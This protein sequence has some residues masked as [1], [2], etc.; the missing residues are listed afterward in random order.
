MKKKCI[1]LALALLIQTVS[2][3]F[4]YV[5]ASGKDKPESS[6]C[7]WPSEMMSQ[8]FGFQNEMR[9]VLL[10]SKI[11]ERRFK[12]NIWKGWL[13]SEQV[14]E[15][16][17]TAL[18]LVTSSV[19]N[20]TRSIASNLITS[21]VLFELALVSVVQS[22]ADWIGIL[23]KDRPIVRDYKTML[24]IESDLF[25]VAYFRSKQVNL[26]L[27]VEWDMVKQLKDVIKKYQDSWLL[28]ENTVELKENVGI[29]HV[30]RDLLKMNA[31]MK[32]FMVYNTENLS[33]YRWCM[34]KSSEKN[35]PAVLQ[36]SDEAVEKLKSDY[37]WTFQKCNSHFNVTISKTMSDSWK[38]WWQDVEKAMVRLKTAFVWVVKQED[39]LCGLSYYEISMIKSYRWDGRTCENLPSLQTTFPYIWLKK[40]KQDLRKQQ[41]NSSSTDDET[42]G[43]S[44]QNKK[45]TSEKKQEWFYIYW[46]GSEYN[47]EYS[48]TM[49]SDF[50]WI[51][52]SI[53]EEYDQSERNARAS[54]L[55]NELKKINALIE[56]IDWVKTQS[57]ALKTQLQLIENY[58][59]TG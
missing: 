22:N 39:D 51:Y 52:D 31:A 2:S 37:M 28:A 42:S 12:V 27:P 46:T 49:N 53:K 56:Q 20:R 1:L 44:V 6:V 23:F 35:C 29:S 54:D 30:I 8:Y 50:L 7:A 11:N 33:K 9:G 10:G 32:H 19:R 40:S 14:L 36:F 58:Q 16:N 18:D 57:D 15:L 59:C 21:A 48:S 47:P 5:D 41:W 38:S 13:F 24:D 25:D 34:D 3:G 43:D 26:T 4:L 55:S 45:T 17:N